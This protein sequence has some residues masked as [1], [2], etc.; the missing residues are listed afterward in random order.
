MQSRT[1][2][3]N[4]MRIGRRQL[5]AGQLAA[6][7]LH[8]EGDRCRLSDALRSE[9]FGEIRQREGSDGNDL[10]GRE[11]KHSPASD[12]DLQVGTAGQELLDLGSSG[13]HLL[14]VIKYEQEVLLAHKGLHLLQE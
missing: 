9:T 6:C 4:R 1:R 5:K 2:L 8:K 3:S 10:F 14:E 12:Q 7:P 11:M 13:D